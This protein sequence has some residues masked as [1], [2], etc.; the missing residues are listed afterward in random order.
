MTVKPLTPI[1]RDASAET[2]RLE[3]EDRPAHDWY[4]F[5][6]SFPPHLVRSYLSR[7]EITEKG[8]VLDPFA[9]TGTTVV[10]CKKRCFQSVGVEAHPMS[11]FAAETK[12]NWRVPPDR[13]RSTARDISDEALS[14]LETSGV[15]DD[16]LLLR[17][18]RSP[19]D[20][21]SLRGLPPATAKLLLTNSISP[22]P[23]HKVLVLLDCITR[24]STPEL[25]GPLRLA[26][27][28]EL[29]SSI[30]NLRFGP[31]VG[32]GPAKEDAPVISVWLSRVRRMADDLEQLGSQAEVPCKIH[33][34]DSR[35]IPELLEASSIDAVITS[36]P[37]P[38]EKDY[39]RTTRLETVL[40]GL[41]TT[42]A[43]LQALKRGM[44]LR[45]NTRNVYKGDDDDR[46]V[47]D[48]PEVQ[49]VAADIEAR[50]IE[51]GK[52]SGFERLY[53]RV[54]KLYFGGMARHLAELR[55]ALRPGARLAYVVGD[56][57]SYLRVMIRTGQILASIAE[58]L[59][60]TVDAIDLFR[61]RQA[62]ATRTQLR[63]E[64]VVLRWPGP[65]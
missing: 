39:T 55:I 51:L 21:Q 23:L 14:I 50:R 65:K 63:E 11:H 9:G 25:A 10:E 28:R 46:W 47:V 22:L 45:S 42:K 64:I 34:G 15:I 38:N 37:Y 57:A 6:L 8:T 48:H 49:R 27:A 3:A 17:R 61:T 4:R 36:P 52:T 18:R 53:A 30:S 54:T 13:L 43:E 41:A 12:T 1:L 44:L 5:V 26:V 29:V 20:P 62:T 24:R 60:Y 59:G 7:F 33:H 40:L 32:I 16:P 58:Q 31:E 2:N 35:K 19:A 56:Q